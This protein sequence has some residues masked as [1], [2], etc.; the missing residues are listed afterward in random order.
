MVNRV[1]KFDVQECQYKVT[2]VAEWHYSDGG[3]YLGASAT[4][5]VSRL[6]RKPDGTFEGNG[7]FGFEYM[8]SIAPCSAG[9]SGYTS[10]TRIIGK[11]RN[12]TD[13]LELT[14]EY[15]PASSTATFSCP[16][17]GATVPRGE[18]VKAHLGL[19]SAKYPQ[20]GG[21]KSFPLPGQGTGRLTITLEPEPVGT[22]N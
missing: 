14:F 17:G 10:P 15:G 9:Y 16:D 18:D 8:A 21:T 1:F 19:T 13:E 5:P 3:V 2:M 12:D 20:E 6:T 4:L 22:Q 11:I 7:P